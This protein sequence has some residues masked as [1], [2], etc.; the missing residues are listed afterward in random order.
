[1]GENIDGTPPPLIGLLDN[2]AVGKPEGDVTN[3]QIT[4]P[5]DSALEF[6]FW[7]GKELIQ[8]KVRLQ[9][10][11]DYH[12]RPKGIGLTFSETAGRATSCKWKGM[13]GSCFFSKGAE[14]SLIV[15]KS[16]FEPVSFWSC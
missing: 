4:E 10:K 7:Q 8:K 12:C 13:W 1:M 9:N 5:D 6:V 15:H 11:R 2:A 16:G 3:V 14:G